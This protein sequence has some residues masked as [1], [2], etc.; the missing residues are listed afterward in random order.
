MLTD[1][2][3]K[4]LRLPSSTPDRS[5][6]GYLEGYLG[7]PRHSSANSVRDTSTAISSSGRWINGPSGDNPLAGSKGDPESPLLANWE[8]SLRRRARPNFETYDPDRQRMDITLPEPSLPAHSFEVVTPRFQHCR[9]FQ[10]SLPEYKGI[11]YTKN[12]LICRL[13]FG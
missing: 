13:K 4:I 2:V 8:S 7:H 3:A 1:K 12:A 10:P 6:C 9:Y 5:G 11:P